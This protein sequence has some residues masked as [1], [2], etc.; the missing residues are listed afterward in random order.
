MFSISLIFL[1][2]L[3]IN[4]QCRAEE[5]ENLLFST[6]NEL[7][8]P[9]IFSPDSSWLLDPGDFEKGITSQTDHDLT[10]LTSNLSFLNDDA[11]NDEIAGGTLPVFA[12][13]AGASCS[14]GLS[15]RGAGNNACDNLDQDDSRSSSSGLNPASID[16]KVA[17]YIDLQT[18][19][20]KRICARTPEIPYSIP[21]CSSGT[22]GEIVMHPPKITFELLWAEKSK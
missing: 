15:R 11:N 13:G 4:N 14:N 3:T 21:V 18:M 8:D 17:P 16:P 5:E 19:Q 2:I 9:S 1:C 10:D 22:T 12:D 20:L 6:T 7:N